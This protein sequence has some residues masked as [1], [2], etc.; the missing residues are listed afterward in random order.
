MLPVI[1]N[2][3]I[4]GRVPKGHDMYNTVK[5]EPTLFWKTHKFFLN[6]EN[7]IDLVFLCLR[8]VNGE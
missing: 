5:I 2:A 6:K 1:Y 8:K 4:N 7:F 3:D